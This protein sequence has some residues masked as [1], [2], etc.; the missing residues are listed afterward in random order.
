[1]GLS[2]RGLVQ[3]IA[4]GQCE[5]PSAALQRLDEHWADL[6]VHWHLP[7]PDLLTDAD[8][9]WM[10]ARDLADA[11]DRTRKDIYNW[12]RAGHIAQ[13][14]GPDGS[15]EYRVSDVVA[16]SSKLRKK[17]IARRGA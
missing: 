13:R 12:A 8:E 16:Y 11:I 9:E 3:T 14:A 7:R 17:R 1:M 6:D 15:P 4:H 10:S 5:D 2:Y